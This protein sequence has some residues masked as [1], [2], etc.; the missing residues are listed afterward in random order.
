MALPALE[1][2][3]LIDV[4]LPPM[5]ADEDDAARESDEEDFELDSL[6]DG[7]SD[8][9]DDAEASDLDGGAEG[10]EIDDVDGESNEDDEDDVDVGPLDDDL[11]D[12]E[13]EP[14]IGADL[15]ADGVAGDSDEVDELDDGDDDGGQEGTNEPVEDEVDESALPGIDADDDGDFEDPSLVAEAWEDELAETSLPAWAPLRWKLR[16]GAGTEVPCRAVAS[17]G[18]RIVGA[19][20][21]LFVVDAGAYAAR[22]IGPEEAAIAVTLDDN[23]TAL[24]ATRRGQLIEVSV[25]GRMTSLGEWRAH[26]GALTLASTPGRA[27]ALELGANGTLWSL[28]GSPRR[29]VVA[30]ERGVLAIAASGASLLALTS[31]GAGPCLQRLRSDDEGWQPMVLDGAA[32]AVASGPAV[33]LASAAQ[34]KVIALAEPTRGLVISRNGGASFRPI[35][36]VGVVAHA[37]AGDD[38]TAPVLALVLSSIDDEAYLVEVAPEGTPL[39]VAELPL[40]PRAGDEA[41][42]D[43]ME[44]VFAMA[45]DA[46]REVAWVASP[47]GLMAIGRPPTH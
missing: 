23:G 18:G 41:E 33:A 37:F 32:R 42:H 38:E 9:L 3:D 35:D 45:W 27:W 2:E 22:R 44:R 19:G 36:L 14:P 1:D 6:D 16:E 40:C 11:I 13:T 15:E 7:G 26:H 39:R 21:V 31:D 34:G 43:P 46:T 12:D 24:V 28:A 4:E 47:S 30:R 20:D 29:V 8:P 17:Q 5:D 25:D 10:S